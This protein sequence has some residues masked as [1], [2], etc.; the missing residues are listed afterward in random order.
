MV[1]TLFCLNIVFSVLFYK[2]FLPDFYNRELASAANSWMLTIYLT[3]LLWAVLSYIFS[4]IIIRRGIHSFPVSKGDIPDVFS[5]I[6]NF[7]ITIGIERPRIDIIDSRQYNAFSYGVDLHSFALVITKG[8]L[9]APKEVRNTVIAREL[10]QIKNGATRL[11]TLINFYAFMPFYFISAILCFTSY[12][13]D[14]LEH[15]FH[16]DLIMVVC[17]VAIVLNYLVMGALRIFLQRELEFQ[18]DAM[19][20][21]LTKDS[22]AMVKTLE[23]LSS[24]DNLSQ[25]PPYLAGFSYVSKAKYLGL[26]SYQPTNAARIRN[27]KSVIN[28]YV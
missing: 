9:S 18:S 6:E 21:K 13:A 26:I 28:T 7:C 22:E 8:L 24:R 11:L 16:A 14:G 23:M 15:M 27:I 2:F 12:M 20:L 19:T 4:D 1:P 10:T 3:Y 5:D 17:M 25:T